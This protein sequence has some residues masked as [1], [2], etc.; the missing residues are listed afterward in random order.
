MLVFRMESGTTWVTRLRMAFHTDR[1]DALNFHRY[2]E[3]YCTVYYLILSILRTSLIFRILVSAVNWCAVVELRVYSADNATQPSARYVLFLGSRERYGVR[4][5]LEAAR[6][7]IGTPGD[8]TFI[9][10]RQTSTLPGHN[11]ADT[12]LLIIG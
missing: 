11:L 9:D 2:H 8:S 1:C 10:S 4:R 6:K 3:H 7:Q 5:T 12:K